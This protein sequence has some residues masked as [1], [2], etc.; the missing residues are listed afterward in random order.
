MTSIATN[1]KQTIADK[2]RKHVSSGLQLPPRVPGKPRS[3]KD[4]QGCLAGR[5]PPPTKKEIRQAVAAEEEFNHRKPGGL[6][7]PPHVPGK[8]RSI[9]DL[10]GCLAGRREGPP[11]TIEEMKQAVADAVV[12]KYL[13]S[14]A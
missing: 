1:D 6:N 9:K 11:L 5:I 2:A 10:E 8:P 14:F 3:I 12:Q 4:L 13:R 7:L